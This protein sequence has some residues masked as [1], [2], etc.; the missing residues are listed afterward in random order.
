MMK[1]IAVGALLVLTVVLSRAGR[2]D[3]APQAPAAD[4]QVNA[5]EVRGHVV[6]ADPEAKV[7]T[8]KVV[9]DPAGEAREVR[10]AVG[11]EALTTLGGFAP[12]EQVVATCQA[13]TSGDSCVVVAIRRTEG[14]Q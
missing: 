1:V 9:A 14:D 4:V 10:L 3:D 12:G 8:L 6:S 7:L 13:D 5:A 2:S 11:G